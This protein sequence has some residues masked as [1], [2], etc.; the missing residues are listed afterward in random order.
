[1]ERDDKCT[2]IHSLENQIEK[3][4][5]SI[6]KMEKEI[7]EFEAEKIVYFEAQEKLDKLYQLEIID[8]GGEYIPY[9]PN[10]EEKDMN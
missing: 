1:M 2:L 3:R 4:D 10:E 9:H 6:K 5:K 7:K 8:S